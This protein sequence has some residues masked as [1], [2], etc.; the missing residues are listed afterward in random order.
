MT[1]V[2]AFFATLEPFDEMHQKRLFILHTE[3]VSGLVYVQL[4]TN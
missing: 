3:N 1:V 4:F 2:I